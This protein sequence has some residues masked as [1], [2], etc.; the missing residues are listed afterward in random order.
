MPAVVVPG[1]QLAVVPVCV[2]KLPADCADAPGA[3]AMETRAAV[4]KETPSSRP[5]R[6]RAAAIPRDEKSI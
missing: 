3:A 5:Y 1:P 2:Q 4:V 6:T